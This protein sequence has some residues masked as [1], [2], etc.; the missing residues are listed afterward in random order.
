MTVRKIDYP[1]LLERGLHHWTI[2][3]LNDRAV[4]PF[5]SSVNRRPLFELLEVY[6]EALEKTGLE[7]EIWVG[8]SF[9]TEKLEPDDLDIL[10]LYGIDQMDQL[11]ADDQEKALILLDT[12]K[13]FVNLRI[14]VHSVDPSADDEVNSWLRF[15][16]TQHDEI[17]PK[18]LVSLRLKP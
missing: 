6:L 1:P 11:P 4:L 9:L 12:Q 15:F 3:Q 7:S 13:I 14:H 8:G 17:T 2:N 5:P 16:G 18:G 10:V